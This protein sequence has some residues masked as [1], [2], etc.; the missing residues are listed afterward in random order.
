MMGIARSMTRIKSAALLL[1]A[2]LT[3]WSI[4]PLRSADLRPDYQ[5]AAYAIRGARVVPVAGDPIEDGTVVVR[6]G[7]IAAVGPA[8]KVEVPFDAEVIEG[9]GLVVYPGF[10]DLYTTA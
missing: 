8:D 4:V 5:P 7:V 2:G 1:A 6:D 10:L 9:K 3:V